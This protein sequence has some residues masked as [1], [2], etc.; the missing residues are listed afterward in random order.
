V[1]HLRSTASLALVAAALAGGAALLLLSGSSPSAPAAPRPV[2]QPFAV[3]PPTPLPRLAQLE[4]LAPVRQ[5]AIARVAPR[6]SARALERVGRRTPEG[7]ANV[8]LVIGRSDATREGVWLRARLPGGATGWLPRSALGG[9]TLITT[10]LVVDRRRLRLTLYRDGRA[11]LRAPVAI[12]RPSAPTPAGRYYV[13]DRLRSY[14]SPMYGPLAFGTS[15]RAPGVTDWPAGG[16]VGIHGTDQPQLIPG[17]VSHGC[18]RL[19]NADIL[20]LGRLMP[21]GTPIVIL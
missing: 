1:A 6:R 17:R 14:R 11:V 16:F 5:Q 7:T 10:R 2:A 20:R 15:A 13:R 18:I 19:R 21:V 9:Y 3:P 4:R 12:G 8:V